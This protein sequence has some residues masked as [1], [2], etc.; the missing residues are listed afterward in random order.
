MVSQQTTKSMLRDKPLKT[1][2]NRVRQAVC[3]LQD[4]R[5]NLLIERQLDLPR[6]LVRQENG[7]VKRCSDSA[8]R[9][10]CLFSTTMVRTVRHMLPLSRSSKD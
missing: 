4:Q 2:E 5:P 6:T 8:R 7:G 1:G 10:C 3:S 9:T